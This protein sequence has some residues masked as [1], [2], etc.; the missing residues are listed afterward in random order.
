MGPT[1]AVKV[2]WVDIQYLTPVCRRHAP[3]HPPHQR[4]QEDRLSPQRQP[5]TSTIDSRPTPGSPD[6]PWHH[7]GNTHLARSGPDIRRDRGRRRNGSEAR[8]AARCLRRHVR[9]VRDDPARHGLR[10]RGCPGDPLQRRDGELGEGRAHRRREIAD[11]SSQRHDSS[12]PALPCPA[13]LQIMHFI[14]F[15]LTF[16][17]D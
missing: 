6:V 5:S 12:H 2:D 16:N 1:E 10:G 15:H 14:S 3:R 4:S 13:L 8:G 11:V 9:R 7:G 17:I